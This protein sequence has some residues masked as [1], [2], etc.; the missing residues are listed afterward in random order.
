MEMKTPATDKLDGTRD[1][2][3]MSLDSLIEMKTP[4]TG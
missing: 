2:A 1:R 3:L 4:A